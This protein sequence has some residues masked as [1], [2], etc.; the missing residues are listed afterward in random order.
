[1]RIPPYY[2]KG[3]WQRFFAGGVVGGILSW[4]IFAYMFGVYQDIQ[5]KHITKQAEEI[6]KLKANIEIWQEDYKKLNEENQKGITLQEINV[7][8]INAE[9]YKFD[10]LRKLDLESKVREDISHLIAKEISTIYDDQDL[11]ER[12]IENRSFTIDDKDYQLEVRG[13]YLLYTNLE[14]QVAMKFKNE[15]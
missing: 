12:A 10:S 8:L 9:K 4:I 13:I 6:R 5:I 1:M 15:K 2:E 3:S 7:K 11:I 14:I